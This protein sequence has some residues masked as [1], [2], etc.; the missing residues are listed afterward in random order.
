M[1][2]L[3]PI[4]IGLLPILLTIIGV[5]AM[6]FGEIDDSP[7]LMLIGLI[8]IVLASILNIRRNRIN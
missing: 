7:G 4:F 2:L 3:K 6:V 5:L 1:K 8:I